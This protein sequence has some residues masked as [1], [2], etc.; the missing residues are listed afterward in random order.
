MSRRRLLAGN[1][2]MNKAIAEL[3]AF[4]DSFAKAASLAAGSANSATQIM[5][6]VPFTMLARAVELSK[7]YGII[8]AAQNVH[9]EASGAYTGETSIS[10]LKELGVTW[11]LIGHSERRQY[12]AESNEVV[13]KKIRA[14]LNADMT[15]VVCVGETR[16]E[17][18]TNITNQVVGR[19]LD[20]A[21]AAAGS[22][23]DK[24]V[25]AYEPVWAIGTGLSATSAQ[26]QEVH[27]FIRTRL[28]DKC[29][30][31]VANSVRILYGG[32]ATP[33]NIDDLLKQEDIDGGLVG[34]ASL[35]PT[36][37]AQMILSANRI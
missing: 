14:C 13:A 23:A 24:I 35:K 3:P 19:Q 21:L 11:T 25:F 9:F 31:S 37:F 30:E 28:R 17:R 26:A 32:S 18:E 22:D 1:W 16:M 8:I 15:P 33:A 27:A 10:M 4:F 34:G 7:P 20:A 6:A 5:F 2:K 36:D 29:N 12:F